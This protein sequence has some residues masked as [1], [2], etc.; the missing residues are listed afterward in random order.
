MK[1]EQAE[2]IIERI[3][4]ERSKGQQRTTEGIAPSFSDDALSLRFSERHANDLRYVAVWNKWL[5]WD[6][7]RWQNDDTLA[8]FDRVRLICREYARQCNKPKIA[9]MVAS[10]KTIAAVERLGKS[11][12]RAAA[13]VEQWDADPWLLNTPG[14]VVDLLTGQMRRHFAADYLT[15]MTGVAPD[16]DCSI[17]IWIKFLKVVTAG[18]DDLINYLQ[19]LSGYSMT[20]VTNEHVLAFLWGTG[21][22]GKK[23]PR[24]DHWLRRRLSLHCADRDF[25]RQQ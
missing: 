24:G 7:M 5:R 1:A 21:A 8:T 25:H 17:D 16:P 13:T 4:R 12:R 11:D 9:A 20:G 14:G 3:K 10:A 6:G 18:D 15:K 23:I 19:R 22:N 2:R